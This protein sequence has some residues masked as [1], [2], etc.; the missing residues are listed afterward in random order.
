MSVDAIPPPPEGGGTLAKGRWRDDPPPDKTPPRPQALDV[1]SQQALHEE[2]LRWRNDPSPDKPPPR[3]QALEAYARHRQ[4]LR[5]DLRRAMRQ[6]VE[7]LH[8][9]VHGPAGKPLP[10]AP[11]AWPK[12][13]LAL[14]A[15]PVACLSLP[16]ILAA[17]LAFGV[18]IAFRGLVA[19]AEP[20]VRLLARVPAL[21]LVSALLAAASVL[22]AGLFVAA[23]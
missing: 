9:I 1:D 10:P 15:V 18:S 20:P 17:A 16:V 2:Y 7:T 19:A 8:R 3:P 4:Q 22:A 13:A 21:T 23:R 11:R 5:E 6:D 12:F 14:A